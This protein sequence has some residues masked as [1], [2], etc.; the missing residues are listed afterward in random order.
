MPRDANICTRNGPGEQV[1]NLRL[2][3][4]EFVDGGHSAYESQT[5]KL[6]SFIQKLRQAEWAEIPDNFDVLV[7]LLPSLDCVRRD[8]DVLPVY[9][10][11]GGI[12]LM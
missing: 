3:Y 1:H 12:D 10:T 11:T 8:E 4:Q 9:R 6:S 5:R 7:V 2:S